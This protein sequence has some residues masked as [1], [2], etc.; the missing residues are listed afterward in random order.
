MDTYHKITE[1][2]LEPKERAK[3]K[4]GLYIIPIFML[5]F[6][7]A[8]SFFW[9]TIDLRWDE[10]F[11]YVIGFISLIIFIVFFLISFQ[12]YRDLDEN[13]KIVFQ[14]LVTGKKNKSKAR[15]NRKSQK[16]QFYLYFGDHEKKV[17]AHLYFK[18]EVGDLIEIH[19]A[20][21]SYQ[22]YFQKKLIKRNINYDQLVRI[23]KKNCPERHKILQMGY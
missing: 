8:M 10:P 23:T 5:I 22:M 1:Q 19:H 20:K 2:S 9:S 4:R 7:G 14:G 13:V 16:D 17:G 12:L 6:S 11:V 18:F 21:H 15:Q 3:L